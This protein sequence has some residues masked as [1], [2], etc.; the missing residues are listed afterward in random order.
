MYLVK[1]KIKKKVKSMGYR[2][3]EGFMGAL[4]L[5]IDIILSRC[6]EYTRPQK[7]MDRDSMQLYMQ[8]HNIR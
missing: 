7:T 8:K 3:T 1:N 2:S 5:A 4:E 6:A